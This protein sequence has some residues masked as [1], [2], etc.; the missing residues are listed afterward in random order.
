QP[1]RT[2]GP[3]PKR[4]DATSTP[5]EQV[6]AASDSISRNPYLATCQE[7]LRQIND[8]V[9]TDRRAGGTDLQPPPPLRSAEER[10]RL[11]RDLALDKAGQGEL[12]GTSYSLLDGHHLATCLLFRDALASL[13]RSAGGPE[14]Q[15]GAAGQR[16]RVV[17]LFDW[18]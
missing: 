5:A 11:V 15:E 14:S 12:D 10:D 2:T 9:E 6:A 7:A 13:E 8:A 4:D 3:R 17:S 1:N 16:E 18:V